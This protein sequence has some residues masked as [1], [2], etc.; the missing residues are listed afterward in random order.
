M[1]PVD[2]LPLGVG[3][4]LARPLEARLLALLGAGLS[5][6]MASVAQRGPKRPVELPFHARDAQRTHDG[7]RVA[8]PREVLQQE[9]LVDDDLARPGDNAHPGMAGFSAANP[10][11]VRCHSPCL[12]LRPRWSTCACPSPR[13][14][15]ASAPNGD[16]LPRHTPSGA[17]AESARIDSWGA[18]RARP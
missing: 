4:S 7:F 15:W 10:F 9:L 17:R 2:L 12:P 1:T 14:A 18:F 16:A 5:R 6:Q 11:E 8:H 13:A 3:R